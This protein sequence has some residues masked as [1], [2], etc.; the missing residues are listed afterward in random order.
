MFIV[1]EQLSHMQESVRFVGAY[2][3]RDLRN[4]G[5]RDE[6]FLRSGHEKQNRKAYATLLDGNGAGIE[7]TL[8]IR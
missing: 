2:M 8:R 4:A 3:I 7:D 5:F 6:T 1:V